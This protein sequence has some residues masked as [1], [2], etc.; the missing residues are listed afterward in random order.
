MYENLTSD[1]LLNE[2]LPIFKA[3]ADANRLKIIGLLANQEL[4]VEQLS[5]LLNL[6]PSTVSH[7]LSILADVDLVSAR[8][9]SYYNFYR[10]ENDA[11]VKMAQHVLQGARQRMQP[12]SMSGQDYDK[13]ILR[14]FSAADGTLKSIPSQRKKRMV[15]LRHLAESFQ[16]GIQYSEKQVNEIISRFY[17]DYASLRRYLVDEGLLARQGGGGLYWRLITDQPAE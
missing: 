7:H 13:K 4:S 5:N 9:E 17:P 1:Q 3:M 15:I 16:P 14:D 11:L 10:L 12:V 2:M 8:A 6:R